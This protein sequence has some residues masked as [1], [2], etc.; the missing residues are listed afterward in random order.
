MNWT[1]N[2]LEDV[3]PDIFEWNIFIEKKDVSSEI[4]NI[5]KILG[6]LRS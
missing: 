5:S 1:T 6:F 3:L 4:E 2:V